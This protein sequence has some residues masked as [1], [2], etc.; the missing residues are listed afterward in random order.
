MTFA[1]P[2]PFESEPKMRAMRSA[3]RNLCAVAALGL[4]LSG[5]GYAAIPAAQ[6]KAEAKWAAAQQAYQ[7][8]DRLIPAVVTGVQG[9]GKQEAAALAEARAKA[10]QIRLDAW[11]LIDADEFKRFQDAQAGLTGALAAAM[12]ASAHC[13]ELASDRNFLALR[14][15]LDEGERR[16][17]A[18]RRDF[19]AAARAYNLTLQ[20]FPTMLWAVTLFRGKMPM[21]VFPDRQDATAAR[22]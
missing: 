19:D 20:T 18:A 16:I 17:A 15:Q 4:G 1:P 9:C 13:P 2:N 8:R 22:R 3:P 6:E 7:Q 14:A 10:A 11:R 5:C 12:A 21:A